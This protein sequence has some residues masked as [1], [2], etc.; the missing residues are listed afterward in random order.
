MNNELAVL[1]GTFNQMT[2]QFRT[3]IQGLE[4][5]IAELTQAHAALEYGDRGLVALDDHAHRLVIHLVF[6]A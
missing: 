2:R 6:F 4:Q 1:A 5:N 3:L